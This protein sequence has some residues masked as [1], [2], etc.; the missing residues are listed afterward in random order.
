MRRRALLP[1]ARA[2]GMR[3]GIGVASLAIS[4][5]MAFWVLMGPMFATVA[6]LVISVFVA[7]L[8]YKETTAPLAVLEIHL[9]S[10]LSSPALGHYYIKLGDRKYAKKEQMVFDKTGIPLFNTAGQQYYHS[11][12]ISQFALGAYEYHLDHKASTAREDFLR[13]ASWLKHT[14]KRQ[15]D[16]YYWEY[17][18]RNPYHPGLGEPPYFS[19]MAQGQGASVLLRA[20]AETGEDAYLQ[21]AKAAI[22]PICF[23]L[24]AGGVSV[25][26][27]EDYIFPQEFVTQPISNILNGAIA[28]YF[29]VYDYYRVTG[30][31]EVKKIHETILHTF[32]RVLARY[33]TGYWSRYNLWPVHLASFRYHSLH[34]A[35]LNML[36]LISG[37]SS[38]LTYA[39]TFE[40][41]QAAAMNRMLYV[42]DNHLRQL[43]K[44]QLGDAKRISALIGNIIEH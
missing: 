19:A 38:F 32:S 35:Q 26:Q 11:V 37:E 18:V 5:F 36:H 44:F 20:F 27:G 6:S 33:D 13:C 31:P 40:R 23:D 2:L 29:G 1:S 3:K 8:L 10:N 9:H 21:A 34:I 17:T 25:V 14:L 41:Y 42:L 39:T 28:A 16:F 4:V 7:F 15:R 12:Y 43:Q 22:R 24:S 30:D